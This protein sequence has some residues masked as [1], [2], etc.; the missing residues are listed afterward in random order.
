MDRARRC[1]RD[2]K[3]PKRGFNLNPS[4]SEGTSTDNKINS[5]SCFDEDDG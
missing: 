4:F 1:R 2:R 3:N 5:H